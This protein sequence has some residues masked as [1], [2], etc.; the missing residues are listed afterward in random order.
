MKTK[1][2]REKRIELPVLTGWEHLAIQAALADL[3]KSNEMRGVSDEVMT[4][5]DDLILKVGADYKSTDVIVE[6]LL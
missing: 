1:S 6:I 4:A 2:T 3:R 5:L